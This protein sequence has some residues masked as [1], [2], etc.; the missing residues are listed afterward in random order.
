[1]NLIRALWCVRYTTHTHVCIQIQGQGCQASPSVLSRALMIREHAY[2]YTSS[3]LM[4]PHNESFSGKHARAHGPNTYR[5]MCASCHLVFGAFEKSR[6][7]KYVTN[8][9]LRQRHTCRLEKDH[10]DFDGH[11]SSFSSK[12]TRQ[13]QAALICVHMLW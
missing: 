8:S 9:S 11:A 5:G 2:T 10:R 4:T 1:M 7:G 12:K 6:V 13:R 3:F